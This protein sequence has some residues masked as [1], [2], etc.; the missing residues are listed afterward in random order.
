MNL[1]KL[2]IASK[3]T[4][5]I[6]DEKI[7]LAKSDKGRWYLSRED[8]SIIGS[9]G[10][11]S[12]TKALAALDIYKAKTVKAKPAAKTATAKPA[13]AEPA[14]TE[15]ATTT[16]IENLH[17]LKFGGKIDESIIKEYN[18]EIFGSRY[19]L[20]NIRFKDSHYWLANITDTET[21]NKAA[22]YRLDYFLNYERLPRSLAV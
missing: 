19:K 20:T 21:G 14:K 4:L 17:K 2:N 3:A 6:A 13:T 15:K 9:T 8:G 1:S 16:K 5:K 10:F 22:N 7:T 11:N 18:K 12:K